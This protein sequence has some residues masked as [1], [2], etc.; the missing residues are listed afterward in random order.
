MRKQT[1]GKKRTARKTRGKKAP[2]AVK[3]KALKK[4]KKEKTVFTQIRSAW[5]ETAAKLKTLL[6]GENRSNHRE[7]GT[8]MA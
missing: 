8:E 3:K 4:P 6:P 2:P 7:D 5:D 1:T